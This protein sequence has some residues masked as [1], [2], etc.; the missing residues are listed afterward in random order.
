MKTEDILIAS[1][2]GLVEYHHI[3]QQ[4]NTENQFIL[5]APYIPPP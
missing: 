1:R 2:C 5:K 3:L 4:I